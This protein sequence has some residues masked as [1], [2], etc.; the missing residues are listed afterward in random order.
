[1]AKKNLLVHPSRF[2]LTQFNM[3]NRIISMS[4]SL[5]KETSF[6]MVRKFLAE[7][8]ITTTPLLHYKKDVDALKYAKDSLIKLRNVYLKQKKKFQKHTWISTAML[9]LNG[10]WPKFVCKI[11]PCFCN[12]TTGYRSATFEISLIAVPETK[13]E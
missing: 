1:M 4:Y 5:L 12:P 6:I 8:Y 13:I 10:F 3:I 9:Y 11:S 7:S 2:R